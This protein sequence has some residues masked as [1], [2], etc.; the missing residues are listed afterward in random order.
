MEN[1]H[2]LLVDF[3][4]EPADGYAERRAAIAMLDERL[5]GSRRITLGGDKGYDTRDFVA[6]CRALRV[7]P[8]VAQNQARRGGSA[9]D[10]RTVRHPGYA[11]SQRRRKAVEE[12]FG[13]GK[14]IGPLRKLK[15]RGNALVDWIFTFTMAVYDLVRIR[16]L[17]RVGVC[18]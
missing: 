12:S 3:Q 13:W 4:I 6:D 16:T 17:I 11:V 5:P 2:A 15:H 7:T 10:P 1:R 14:V 8:H 18:T 9:L